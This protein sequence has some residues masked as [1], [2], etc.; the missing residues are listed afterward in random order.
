MKNSG[1]FCSLYLYTINKNANNTL[2]AYTNV[3]SILKIYEVS[4]TEEPN[5]IFGK[6]DN[7]Y[8]KIHNI[9]TNKISLININ[10][11]IVGMDNILFFV[12]ENSNEDFMFQFFYIENNHIEYHKYTNRLENINFIRELDNAEYEKEKDYLLVNEYE[13]SGD[14]YIY[15]NDIIY[16]DFKSKTINLDTEIYN[17]FINNDNLYNPHLINSGAE[18]NLFKILDK[19]ILYGYNDYKIKCNDYNNTN[20]MKGDFI[21]ICLEDN[22]ITEL[23]MPVIINYGEDIKIKISL[24]FYNNTKYSFHVGINSINNIIKS[25]IIF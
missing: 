23:N 7:K 10:K 21:F 6:T 15:F 14:K 3:T 4:W 18:I 9:N 20:L 24:L 19:Q 13:N 8:V 2:I 12:V 22:E 25:N 17:N 11:E 16:G 5:F 1:L